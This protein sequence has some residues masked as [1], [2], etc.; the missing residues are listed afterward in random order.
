MDYNYIIIT[1]L[2]NTNVGIYTL[3]VTLYDDN[4]FPYS[5]NTSYSF[6]VTVKPYVNLTTSDINYGS[7]VNPIKGSSSSKAYYDDTLYTHNFT[8]NS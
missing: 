4:T 1:P 3:T 5:K 7:K 8:V 6:K 2:L